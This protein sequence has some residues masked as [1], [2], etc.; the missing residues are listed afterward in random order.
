MSDQRYLDRELEKRQRGEEVERDERERLK[1]SRFSCSSFH[2]LLTSWKVLLLA[3]MEVLYE[4]LLAEKSEDDESQS[5]E[6]TQALHRSHP[7]SAQKSS[8]T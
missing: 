7:A 4:R 2:F 8:P 5:Q 6:S 1:S 3:S